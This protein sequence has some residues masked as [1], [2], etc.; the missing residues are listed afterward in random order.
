MGDF[1]AEGLPK[2]NFAVQKPGVSPDYFHAM[3]IPLLKGR[4]FNDRDTEKAPS[5]A[6]IGE[7]V[8]RRV[9]PGEDPIGKR[10]TLEDRTKPSD[11]LTVVGVVADVKLYNM[12]DA[13]P[14]AVYQPFPQVTRQGFLSDMTYVIR[15][16]GD[17]VRLGS[18]IREQLKAV[19]PD[20][21]VLRIA[22]MS[23]LVAASTSEPR[24][25][26]E[27]IGSFAILAL[28]LAVIGIYGVMSYFVTERTREIGIRMAVGAKAGH[29]LTL[30]VRRGLLLVAAG[31][32]CGAAGAW[33]VTRVLATLL[34][35]LK[36]T[37]P[38]TFAAAALLLV[39][40]ATAAT[41]IPARRATQVDP[42]VALRYE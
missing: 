24:F 18:T 22:T 23:K 29:V 12:T 19:D 41:F 16:S 6:I 28:L 11:W 30:V 42:S 31:V 33:G 26:A 39:M 15:S 17:P 25:Q 35:E 34:F 8:A 3:G 4:F 13:A 21:P 40:V 7:S 38:P 32:V 36:P 37:D 10:V 14:P 27:I 5:V 20:L 1:Y 2:P 9:W